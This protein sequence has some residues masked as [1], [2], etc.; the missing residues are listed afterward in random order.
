[1]KVL[2]RF[3]LIALMVIAALALLFI[4]LF[5]GDDSAKAVELSAVVAF[6]IQLVAFWVVLPPRKGVDQPGNM[7][8]RWSAGA[9]TRFLSLIFYG[10]IATRV[11][12]LPAA[13]ALLS[14][15]TFFFVTM[16]IE[17][18]LLKNAS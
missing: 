17:P 6:V 18:L 8:L 2:V 13:A 10:L 15:A 7:L 11:L 4:R 12:D 14:L 9:V 1:V 3:G 16:L 5:P